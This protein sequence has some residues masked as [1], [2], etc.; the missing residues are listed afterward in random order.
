MSQ[1]TTIYSISK[2][3]FEDLK[4]SEN[5]RE[6]KIF[7]KAKEYYTFEN[8]FCGIEFVLKKASPKNETVLM[9]IFNP[10]DYLGDFDFENSDVVD[11]MDFIES[12]NYVPYLT[13]EK[14]AGVNEIISNMTEIDIQNNYSAKDLNENEIYPSNW[15]DVNL[16]GKDNNL[17]FLIEDFI[18]LKKIISRANAEKNYLL[19]CSG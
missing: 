8:S 17:N 13:S 18:K 9:S 5:R 16:K 11:M 12:G 2:D 15:S 6:F 7:T 14:I 19:I 4:N 3:I 10:V 1:S